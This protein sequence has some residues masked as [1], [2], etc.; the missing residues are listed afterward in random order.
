MLTHTNISVYSILL[1]HGIHLLLSLT[2]SAT[3]TVNET[4]PPIMLPAGGGGKPMQ[5]Q[6]KKSFL[7]QVKL[8]G[9][10]SIIF[11]GLIPESNS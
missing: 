4:F 11:S 6:E 2:W 1:L 10:F 5:S 7:T 8:I 3:C 9:T